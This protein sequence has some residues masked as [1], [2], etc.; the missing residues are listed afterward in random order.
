[1]RQSPRA[2]RSPRHPWLVY[3]AG[4][5]L[6]RRSAGSTRYISRRKDIRPHPLWETARNPDQHPEPDR[7]YRSD[8]DALKKT[9]LRF[10]GF[11]GRI[12]P[13]LAHRSQANGQENANEEAEDFEDE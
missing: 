3:P 6:C 2:S 5:S 10:F 1:M 13:K 11:D 8:E 9:L 12:P 7:Y 4:T